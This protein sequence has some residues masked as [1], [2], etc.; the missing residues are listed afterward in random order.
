MIRKAEVGED[1]NLFYKFYNGNSY[2]EIYVGSLYKAG[3]GWL[4]SPTL[5][6]SVKFTQMMLYAIADVMYA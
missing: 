5:D 4:F 3:E 1:F 2:E 6:N